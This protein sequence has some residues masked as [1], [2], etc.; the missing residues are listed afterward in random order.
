MCL[1]CGGCL[2]IFCFYDS[3]LLRLTSFAACGLPGAIE[4]FT[5]ALVKHKKL[6]ILTQK[7]MNA[8]LYNYI[9][10]PMTL[11]SITVIHIAYTLG[12]TPSSSPI[13]VY[14]VIFLVYINGSFYNKLTIE[15][16]IQH[17]VAMRLN[18]LNA[19]RS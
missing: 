6:G 8:I 4:Y 16:H 7:R 2:P 17:K 18:Y 1:L 11:Y 15:N 19:G 5:L 14:Y 13:V 10:F 3:N 9:R 12:L